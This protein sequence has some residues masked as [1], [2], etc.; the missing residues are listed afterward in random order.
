MVQQAG[1]AAA[2]EHLTFDADDGGDVRMP[3]AAD[4]LVGRVEDADGAALVAV[5][6]GVAAMSGG[7][8]GR[9]G[10]D[11]LDLLVKG[12]ELWPNLGDG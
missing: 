5:A 3:V 6:S 4:E 12:R 11:L 10:S 8:R 1:L 7:D 2:G 9:G